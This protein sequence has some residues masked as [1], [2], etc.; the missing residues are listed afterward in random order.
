MNHCLIYKQIPQTILFIDQYLCFELLSCI[1]RTLD[2]VHLSIT[3]D[4]KASPNKSHRRLILQIIN[5]ILYIKYHLTVQIGAWVGF[6]VIDS[7]SN[8]LSSIKSQRLRISKSI[9]VTCHRLLNCID[10]SLGWI[11][12]DDPVSNLL[13]SIK[14]HRLVTSQINNRM[15]KVIDY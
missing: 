2:Q 5:F 4:T 12:R 1:D 13:S 11:H 10:R 15:L 14:S 6:T 8:L 9:Y 7:V 3:D